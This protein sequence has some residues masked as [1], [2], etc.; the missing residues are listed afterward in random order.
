[1]RALKSEVSIY[2]SDCESP[3]QHTKCHAVTLQ[4]AC[5]V[6][7]VMGEPHG[8]EAPA[9]L[10]GRAVDAR[11][12]SIHQDGEHPLRII[13]THVSRGVTLDGLGWYWIT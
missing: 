5:G 3:Y 9:V 7:I 6:G 11:R 12:V 4:E 10:I 13:R 2:D 8:G 1:M